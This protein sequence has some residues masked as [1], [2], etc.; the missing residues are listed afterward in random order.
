MLVYIVF[1]FNVLIDFH[2]NVQTVKTTFVL[3][4]LGFTVLYLDVVLL[5]ESM[6]P[7]DIG[8]Q[9]AVRQ[10]AVTAVALP[11]HILLDRWST[12]VTRTVCL[13]HLNIWLQWDA[14][15]SS[16]DSAFWPL[17]WTRGQNVVL[18]WKCVRS[19]IKISAVPWS[20]LIFIFTLKIAYMKWKVK[21]VWNL[22]L[23]ITVFDEVMC[24]EGNMTV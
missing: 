21:W 14:N 22:W 6:C 13:W 2:F 12:R 10:L 8:E 16:T 5:F 18:R 1:L 19:V 3:W 15:R 23:S 20:L 24:Q 11:R 9:W 7:C 17:R 4:I